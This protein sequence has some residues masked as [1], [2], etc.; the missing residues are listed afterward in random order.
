MNKNSLVCLCLLP[1]FLVAQ[2]TPTI[3]SLRSIVDAHGVDDSLRWDAMVSLSTHYLNNQPD[4]AC[5]FSQQFLE[6]A[7][8]KHD[9]AAIGRALY[10]LGQYYASQSEHTLAL[11]L[12]TQSLASFDSLDNQEYIARG[13]NQIGIVYQYLH[14]YSQSLVFLTRSLKA[15]D[16]QKNLHLH[17]SV[18]NN[19]GIVYKLQGRYASALDSYFHCLEI[20]ETLGEQ[21]RKGTVLLNIGNIFYQQGEYEQA[22]DYYIRSRK[23]KE[24]NQDQSGVAN[25]LINIGG[26]YFKQKAYDQALE[27]YVQA[28]EI[29]KQL[30]DRTGMTTLLANIGWVYSIRKEYATALTYYEQSSQLAESL[31][32]ALGIA[33]G[34]YNSGAIYLVQGKLA[35]ALAS[36]QEANT[37]AEEAGAINL[38]LRTTNLLYRVHRQMG[39]MA[40]ALP[41]Y[42]EYIELRDSLNSRKNQQAL[43]RYEYQKQALADSIAFAKETEIKDLQ[44]AEHEA[45]LGQQRIVLGAVILGLGLIG[46]LAF[47]IFRGKK[48]S[49]ELLLNILPA[50]TAA[51]LKATGTAAAKEYENVSI[52]FSDF[53]GFTQLST[54]LTAAELVSEI[55]TCF[56]AFDQIITTYGLE[57]IK[58]I[59]DAYMAAGGLPDP[60]S[61]S[62]RD[63]VKAGLAMQQFIAQRK[64]E[65]G[66]AGLPF[67]EMRV[68][69]HTG[70]VIAGVVGVKKF[71][72]D[73]WGDTVN[74]ASRMESSG[75]VGQV[76]ISASTYELVQDEP[77]LA[78]TSRGA[79][80]AKGKGM[81][82]MYFVNL[83]SEAIA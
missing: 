59:G 18:R 56:K 25:T 1:V 62:T 61:A 73:V 57:K 71:Q 45:A 26:V 31:G 28:L 15:L 82:E 12:Y 48:R 80:E 36:A 21:K 78:F 69:I 11:E 76:N 83:S 39:N 5:Y 29:K 37:I 38:K 41:E 13:L 79:I 58:T 23:I 35:Q 9:Q 8:Q 46:A 27:S 2:S 43:I 6:E 16:P 34:L 20:W 49:D 22:L 65:R 60:M 30:G 68:G 64:S 66:A 24:A 33:E 75:E 17:A 81:M 67:F 70:P 14:D 42:E 77:G 10:E 52:L 72:Y 44:I 74:T 51:E 50:E 63:V 55:D 3:D 47:S 53:K 54:Q 19:L 4:S 40:R 7:E 32:N